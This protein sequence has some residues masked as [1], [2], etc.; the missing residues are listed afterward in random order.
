MANNSFKVKS[1]IINLEPGSDATTVK[2]E[3]R[4]D[5]A[6]GKIR[7]HDGTVEQTVSSD[8]EL[9][10]HLGDPTDA[11]PASAITNTPAGN[12]A[13]TTVQAALN[14]LDGDKTARV[15]STTDNAVVR[16]DGI[17]GAQQDSGVT[18]DDSDNM[19]IP[20]N[21]RSDGTTIDL[22]DAT[23]ASIGTSG[24]ATTVNIGN[25]SGSN[26]INIGGANSTVNITGTVSNQNVVN[27]NVT[28]KLVTI[29][30]GGAAASGGAAGIEVEENATA[31]AYVKTSS[32]RNSWELKAP[33]TNGIAT[34]TPG[35][36]N[37]TVAL[38][39]AS[40]V[41]TNKDIDGGTA[42]N[43][44]RITLPKASKATLDALTRKEGTLVFA[45]DE[46]KVYADNGT[47]LVELGASSKVPTMQ[48]FTSGSGT[49]TRPANC[50]WIRV[51]MVGGGGGG[52]GSSNSASNAGGGGGGG[53]TT[54]GSSLLTANGGGGGAAG[55]GG[56]ASGGTASLGTGPIGIALTGADG[57]GAGN[58][59]SAT[60]GSGGSG[61][62]SP[63]GGAGTGAGNVA[64]SQ[65]IANTGSGGAG[66]GSPASA[67]N[68]YG[69]GG[70]AGGYID[71]I[72]T[73]PS[74]TYAYAVG[75][76]GT[77]GFAGSSGYQGGAGSLGLIIVEEH[78]T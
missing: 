54:F 8:S 47:S 39:A 26:V 55:A 31:T 22:A 61:G 6:A 60:A 14:E 29:N 24:S 76:A 64:G 45:S 62:S 59:G 44:S 52:A 73:S 1:G 16:F 63:F 43:T 11:H 4:V 9:S 67:G 74:S 72:I 7:W 5:S 27:L 38:L 41:L 69:G 71:A 32:D 53:A 2:G 40:Q 37:D 50:T 57:G 18:V 21:L 3:I 34:L 23:T 51:R 78:Y 10:S 15:A 30:D 58:T 13:A 28:D 75:D 48:I 20:G 46:D 17:T 42:S 49:Y 66:G 56:R 77:A 70:G 33:N 68:I 19:I 25:G 12:I 65:A 35:A 36:S